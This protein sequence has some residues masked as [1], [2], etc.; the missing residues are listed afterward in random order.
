LSEQAN[1]S[2]SAA[3]CLQILLMQFIL[4][5]ILHPCIRVINFIAGREIPWDASRRW[6]EMFKYCI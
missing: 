5:K 1:A 4:Q 3:D 2:I 6:H